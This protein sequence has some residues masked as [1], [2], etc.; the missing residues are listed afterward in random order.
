M[1][2]RLEKED[3]TGRSVEPLFAVILD[4]QGGDPVISCSAWT[5]SVVALPPGGQNAIRSSADSLA[6]S[7]RTPFRCLLIQYPSRHS[8]EFVEPDRIQLNLVMRMLKLTG[9]FVPVV[10]RMTALGIAHTPKKAE[11]DRAHTPWFGK[12][13]VSLS[14]HTNRFIV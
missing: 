12:R 5:L 1:G 6:L 4:H 13:L 9:S 7:P 11:G 3:G 14:N 2:H 10:L 8:G